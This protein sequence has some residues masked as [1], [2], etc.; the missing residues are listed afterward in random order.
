MKIPSKEELVEFLEY[1]ADGYCVD[2]DNDRKTLAK[3]LH[4]YL[5]NY[6]SNEEPED[7]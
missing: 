5:M 7:G 2:D 4:E 1:E 6:N 3:L